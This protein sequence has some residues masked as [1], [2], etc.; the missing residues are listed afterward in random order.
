VKRLQIV[1]LVKLSFWETLLACSGQKL[2]STDKKGNVNIYESRKK[3][4][5]AQG[6]VGV[7]GITPDVEQIK[8]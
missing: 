3:Q 5:I 1:E 6:I 4:V 2:Y 7:K 8:V